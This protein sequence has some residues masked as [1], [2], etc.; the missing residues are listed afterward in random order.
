MAT[1][2][3]KGGA[4][5]TGTIQING[6][7]RLTIDTAGN[8]TVGGNITASGSLNIS[9]S[10]SVGGTF[11]ISSGTLIGY[12]VF[13]A[14]G[15]Y[16]KATNNPSFVI[17]EGTGGGG[18]ASGNGGTSSFGT[19]ISITGGAAAGT[20]GTATGGDINSAGMPGNS[21][22]GSSAAVGVGAIGT[23]Y[24]F[25]SGATKY[26]TVVYPATSVSATGGGSSGYS[27]K[28]ILASSLASSETVTVGAAGSGTTFGY[29]GAKAGVV[30]VW[31]YT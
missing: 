3:L 16:T 11:P 19:H 25:G 30:I 9:G 27:K 10:V 12:Q 28:I 17:V 20:G 18:G 15:T 24:T 7:D 6:S 5:T 2:G 21:D 31:E 14:S 13:T 22:S 29:P 26:G 8:V 23:L 4:D 1:I